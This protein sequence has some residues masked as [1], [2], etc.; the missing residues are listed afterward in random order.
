MLLQHSYHRKCIDQWLQES[1]RCPVCR[2]E[3]KMPDE[4]PPNNNQN[5][6]DGGTFIVIEDGDD[7]QPNIPVVIGGGID[8]ID[9]PEQADEWE[10]HEHLLND[11]QSDYSM[12]ITPNAP[13]DSDSESDHSVQISTNIP[14]ET[15]NE[16]DHSVDISSTNLEGLIIPIEGDEDQNHAAGLTQSSSAGSDETEQSVEI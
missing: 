10:P 6:N 7:D 14:H 16:S 11:N 15:D 4:L 2:R 1:K 13:H 5:D 9:N 12:D 3:V 8:E